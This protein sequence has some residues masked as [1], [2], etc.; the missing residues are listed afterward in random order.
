LIVCALPH[1]IGQAERETVRFNLRKTNAK[2]A[3]SYYI[4][5]REG[6]AQAITAPDEEF[7]SFTL[8]AAISVVKASCGWDESSSIVVNIN[9]AEVRVWPHFDG[10]H[11]VAE[12]R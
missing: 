8:A 4:A 3:I 12:D 9:S 2:A 6:W 7:N 11:W 1:S 5:E 10:Q